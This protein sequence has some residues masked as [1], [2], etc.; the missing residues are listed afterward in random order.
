VCQV[1][2][3]D[4]TSPCFFA[5]PALSSPPVASRPQRQFLEFLLGEL[6][7]AGSYLAQQAQQAA[8]SSHADSDPR[9]WLHRVLSESSKH[10]EF[11]LESVAYSH[12]VH[13]FA[14][15]P[16]VFPDRTFTV[17][18]SS[19]AGFVLQALPSV[20]VTL[21]VFGS[22]RIQQ[23]ALRI[24]RDVLPATSPNTIDVVVRTTLA[25]CDAVARW[26]HFADPTVAVSSHTLCSLLLYKVSQTF[27]VTPASTAAHALG[28]CSQPVGLGAGRAALMVGA[29]ANV[30]LRTLLKPSAG[31][32]QEAASSTLSGVLRRASGYITG[33]SATGDASSSFTCHVSLALATAALCVL[34]GE[35]EVFR[36]GGRFALANSAQA[37]RAAAAVSAVTSTSSPATSSSFPSSSTATTSGDE[38]AGAGSGAAG[39]GTP[40]PPPRTASAGTAVLTDASRS[41]ISRTLMRVLMPAVSEG[42]I[43]SVSQLEGIA[44]V[45]FDSE[46]TPGVLYRTQAIQ[47][48]SIVPVSEV[49]PSPFAVPFSTD[50]LTQ[51]LAMVKM[52]TGL[53]A[54]GKKASKDAKD[55][56]DAKDTKTSDLSLQ[57]VESNVV[58]RAQLQRQATQTLQLVLQHP[59]HAE[60][61]LRV[62]PMLLAD[63]VRVALVPVSL[64]HFIA[65]RWLAER[66]A[67]LR[68]RMLDA[69]SGVLVGQ[70][71]AAQHGKA[72]ATP[73]ES[74]RDRLADQLASMM[75]M[76]KALCVRA[77]ERNRDDPD[78]AAEWLL[79]PQAEAFVRG[80]GLLQKSAGQGADARWLASRE[81][82]LVVGMPPRLCY[83]AL[84]MYLDNN[85]DAT[86]WL[87]EFGGNYASLPWMTG[88]ELDTPSLARNAEKL[89]V[90]H[91]LPRSLASLR[92]P[93]DDVVDPVLVLGPPGRATSA[94]WRI[95]AH[96]AP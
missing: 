24:L 64:P 51:L 74:A 72:A 17:S 56:K 85:N 7:F 65:P 87:L 16:A 47:L 19:L 77:L 59:P 37:L 1:I 82:G 22:P 84:E 31:V 39:A 30:L 81:L 32:W 90:G 58:W 3:P 43:V 33:D 54:G 5:P 73:E 94:S 71:V 11:Q 69:A 13:L 36:C 52:D 15:F 45:V 88:E 79:G 26:P 49:P 10:T 42:T 80:G 70:D 48:S 28:I 18:A 50:L 67:V 60:A 89:Y 92:V 23:L 35:P 29:E 96:L 76:D 25:S 75:G 83:H 14:L 66:S 38:V 27:C 8:A 93:P 2:A 20:L 68:E 55:A 62:H 63:L 40:V 21:L 44:Q 86:A 6:S 41:V 34:G 12:L 78:R 91:C 46:I 4:L 57:A 9:A 61:A 53:A 95:L